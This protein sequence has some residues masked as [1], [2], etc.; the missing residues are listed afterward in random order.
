MIHRMLVHH[1]F[2]RLKT[3]KWS[4]NLNCHQNPNHLIVNTF[5]LTPKIMAN[6]P[7]GAYT[8]EKTQS[9]QAKPLVVSIAKWT[10]FLPNLLNT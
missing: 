1:I 3:F 7:A 6:I 5:S 2:S 9:R 8:I 4:R 10:I